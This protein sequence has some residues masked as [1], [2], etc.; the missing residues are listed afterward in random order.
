MFLYKE[1]EHYE[2]PLLSRELSLKLKQKSM[3]TI[4]N[5]EDICIYIHIPFCRRICDFC[6]YYKVI[7]NE[8]KISDY[9]DSLINELCNFSKLISNK[10]VSCIHFGGGS[11]SVLD[12]IEIGKILNCLYTNF[13]IKQG[14]EISFEGNVLDFSKEN[15]IHMLKSNGINRI[16]F[17]IQTFNMKIREKYGLFNN[18]SL[19]EKVCDNAQ[20]SGMI[21]YNADIMYGFPEGNGKT[22]KDDIEKAFSLD[23][24]TIDLYM[25]N[26][27]PNTKLYNL[28]PNFSQ[29]SLR[30]N[31]NEYLE[32]YKDMYKSSNVRFLMSN[33]I[34][35]NAQEC[36]K[37]LSANLS[38]NC[39]KE[40][41]VLGVGA[42]S[43]GRF[44]LIYYKNIVDIN[45]YMENIRENGFAIDC[46]QIYE[47]EDME[48][49]LLVMFPNF[50][51]I[52]KAKVECLKQERIERLKCLSNQGII[53]ENEN[54]YYLDATGMFFAG[55]ISKSLYSTKEKKNSTNMVLYNLK[56]KVNFYN[57]DY[58]QITQ[59]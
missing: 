4:N 22:L 42:S 18:I 33:T 24:N 53:L 46:R 39:I 36:S 28:N 34:T 21:N 16:S 20:K 58:M 47:N 3:N 25:L 48:D 59:R 15:Y 19:I 30:K 52:E 38:N 17:G 5:D 35:K 23:I 1:N 32:V 54:E 8:Q 10:S 31:T 55:N 27:F 50:T 13:S 51:K 11:P 45:I 57:Q 6:N 41:N 14:C 44:G 9:C 40:S 29:T 56:K 37:Y 26:I 12:Y 43:R 7:Y 49:R 2:Y